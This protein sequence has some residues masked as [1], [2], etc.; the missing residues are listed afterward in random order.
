MVPDTHPSSVGFYPLSVGFHPPFGG[1]HPSFGGFHPS[2]EQFRLIFGNR[3]APL[4]SSVSYWLPS[5]AVEAG[6]TAF[7]DVELFALSGVFQG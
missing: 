1:F 2:F 4:A 5:P 3:P 7:P 6:A